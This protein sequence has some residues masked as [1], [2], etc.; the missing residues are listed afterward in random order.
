MLQGTDNFQCPNTVTCYETKQCP[1][2][3][4]VQSAACY[5]W[6]MLAQWIS[7]QGCMTPGA[8]GGHYRAWK[9]TLG[10]SIPGN[11]MT[12]LLADGPVL[13]K[14]ADK[15]AESQQRVPRD[16]E[17]HKP[18]CMILCCTKTPDASVSLCETT[19]ESQDGSKSFLSHPL[20][21]SQ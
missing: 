8:L 17:F 13:A 19:G 21:R 6:L 18:P 15:S 5:R 20:P 7:F 4:E 16:S 10:P 14:H 11:F 9:E 12:R 1:A 3:G 2:Y